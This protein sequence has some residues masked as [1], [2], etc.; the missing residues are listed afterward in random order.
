M[1]YVVTEIMDSI[2]LLQAHVDNISKGR[3]R[4]ISLL[5]RESDRMYVV[6]HE[7]EVDEKQKSRRNAA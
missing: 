6:T 3:G 4:V 7:V 1:R 2:E 5:W